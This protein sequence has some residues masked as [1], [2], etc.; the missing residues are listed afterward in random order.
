[1]NTIY[2]SKQEAQEEADRQNR[3]NDYS[4]AYVEQT[5]EG[6]VVETKHY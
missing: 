2:K 5:T 3:G 6:F 4:F 1:M